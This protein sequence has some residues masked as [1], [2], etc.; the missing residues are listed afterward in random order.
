[1]TASEIANFAHNLIFFIGDLIEDEDDDIWT[2]TI[3]KFFDL[4][5][6]R[7]ILLNYQI[8]SL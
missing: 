8:Q 5:T 3:I 7:K 4:A 2:T 6:Q 1:M